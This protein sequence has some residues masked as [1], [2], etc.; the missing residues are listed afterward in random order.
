[1][2][3]PSPAV[4]TLTDLTQAVRHSGACF[5]AD[6]HLSAHLPQTMAQFEWFCQHIAPQ[7]AALFILGDLFEFW[8]G[9]D[10]IEHDPTA[11]HTLTLLT[12]LH[13]Q[14]VV[15]YFMAGNRDFL[16]GQRFAQQ[17][18]VQHLPDPCLVE[19]AGQ[20]V[21]LSHGD[22]LCTLDTDYQRFRT[23]AHRGWIQR[24][25]LA[26]PRR[27]RLKLAN[28][29]RHKSQNYARAQPTLLPAADG[30]HRQDAVPATVEQWFTRYEQNQLIHGHTHRPQSHQHT[31]GQRWVLPDWECDHAPIRWGYITWG[32]NA[33]LPSRSS[34]PETALAITDAAQPALPQ[35]HVFNTLTLDQ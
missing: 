23:F 26:W 17:A 3:H 12:E 13:K 10:L 27:W 14:G 1:M 31:Q 15:V 7:Y 25:F 21:L 22:L 9:D 5:V 32:G 29:L 16:V 4:P 33:S 11:Q 2:T 18:Y 30:T 28:H 24:L 35:L 20:P 19:I 6:L 34:P 8:V